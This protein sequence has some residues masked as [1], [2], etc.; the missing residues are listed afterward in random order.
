MPRGGLFLLSL[1]R[2]ERSFE[3]PVMCSCGKGNKHSLRE[4]ARCD[5]LRKYG[6]SYKP[7]E[8]RKKK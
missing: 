4:A 6:T 7:R 2:V 8:R 3:M 1:R 5:G